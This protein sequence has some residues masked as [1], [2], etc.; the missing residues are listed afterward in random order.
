MTPIAIPHRRTQNLILPDRRRLR[1]VSRRSGRRQHNVHN[2]ATTIH[3]ALDWLSLHTLDIP[4]SPPF[5]TTDAYS[6]AFTDPG[7][8]VPRRWTHPSIL[9]WHA[10]T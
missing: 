6:P 2:T 5:P 1:V 8:A 4:R 9:L 7:A 10:R 3:N